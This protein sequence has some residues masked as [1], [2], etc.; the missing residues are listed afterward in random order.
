[1]DDTVTLLPAEAL[2]ELAGAP[3][4]P[5]VTIVAVN[6]PGQHE[7]RYFITEQETFPHEKKRVLMVLSY[8]K[9]MRDI[10]LSKQMPLPPSEHVVFQAEDI[11]M[12][13]VSVSWEHLSHWRNVRLVPDLYYF[14]SNGYEDFQPELIPWEQRLPSLVW[15]GS[16]TGLFGQLLSDLDTLPRYRA[17]SLSA[18]LGAMADVG[19]SDVVQTAHPQHT[20]LIRERLTREGILR[21]YVPMPEMARH[22]FILDIDGNSNSWNFMMKL[23]LGCC[24]LRVESQWRQWFSDRLI[25]WR[26]YVPVAPDLSDFIERANWCFANLEECAAIAERGRQF[27]LDMTFLDEMS[28]A[29]RTTFAEPL[30]AAGKSVL[31]DEA[32]GRGQ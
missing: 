20:D 22:R 16:S 23:R 21:P 8:M 18:Q 30:T 5:L 26:H 32:A 1:M 9:L 10:A 28:H 7:L 29:A 13:A 15:R 6:A 19:L 2:T 25:A 3:V 11:P 24:V 31:L 17:C 4:N 27:A 12:D 14:L